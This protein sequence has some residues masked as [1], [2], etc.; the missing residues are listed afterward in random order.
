[1]DQSQADRIQKAISL[2][3]EAVLLLQN[4]DELAGVRVEEIDRHDMAGGDWAWDVTLSF[5]DPE[6]SAQ[7]SSITGLR[8]PPRRIFRTARVEPI[9]GTV[10]FV[11][12]REPMG[13]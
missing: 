6:D 1:M 3:R 7:E 11:K 5:L 8:I 9:S 2:A 12:I 10:Q 4:T 13:L